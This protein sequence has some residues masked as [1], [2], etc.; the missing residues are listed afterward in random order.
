LNHGSWYQKLLQFTDAPA[1][2]ALAETGAADR[3]L[4]DVQAHRID[5]RSDAR[6][7][8]ETLIKARAKGQA[9]ER[10]AL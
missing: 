6:L 3:L 5:A 1:P 8:R 7:R 4:A 9:Q 2:P 10:L